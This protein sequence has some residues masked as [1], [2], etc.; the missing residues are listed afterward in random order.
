MRC[1]GIWQRQIIISQ[2]MT[3]KRLDKIR[4]DPALGDARD[5]C[6]IGWWTRWRKELRSA[7][8][9]R[10]CGLLNLCMMKNEASYSMSNFELES[11]SR[12]HYVGK[13]V[14]SNLY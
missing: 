7:D 5:V 12:N 1:V 14:S 2:E 8:K 6:R 4:I 10:Q 3:K 9:E 11:R 13:T